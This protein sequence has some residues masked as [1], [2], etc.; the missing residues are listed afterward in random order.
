LFGSNW[1]HLKGLSGLLPNPAKSHISNIAI[2]KSSRIDNF[3]HRPYIFQIGQI[4]FQNGKVFF[5][6]GHDGTV[7]MVEEFH[8]DGEKFQESQ[9]W[10]SMLH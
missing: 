10:A 6:W 3:P 9:F 1:A 4:F 2:K 7:G 8:A 5:G